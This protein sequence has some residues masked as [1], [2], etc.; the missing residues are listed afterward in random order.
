[1]QEDIFAA[2]AYANS[3]EGIGAM[4]Q[5]VLA[6]GAWKPMQA[7]VPRSDG[8]ARMVDGGAT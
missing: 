7:P 2:I 4:F 6:A 5:P 3:D 8:S 1:M